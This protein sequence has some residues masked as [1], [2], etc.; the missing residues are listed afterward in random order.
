MMPSMTGLGYSRH[1]L[2]ARQT[3]A[4]IVEIEPSSGVRRGDAMR[5]LR[6]RDAERMSALLE[7][8]QERLMRNW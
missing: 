2:R 4:R 7:A 3:P 6:E 1:S 8:E 5:K